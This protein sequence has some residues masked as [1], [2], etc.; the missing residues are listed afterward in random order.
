MKVLLIRP[1]PGNERFGLGPFFKVEPLGLEYAAAALRARG[2]DPVV[3]EERFEGRPVSWLRRHQAPVVGISCLHALEYDRV[4]E[5][6]RQVRRALPE[7]FIVIGG[8]AAAAWSAPLEGEA[9]DAIVTDDGEVILPLLVEAIAKRTPLREVPG[10][11]L[12]T[13]EGWVVTAS[14]ADRVDLDAVPAPARDLVDR[15]R[16]RYQCLLFRPVWLVETARGCPFRCSFCS[17]WPLYGRSFRERSIGAVVEDIV[18]AGPHLFI[19][20]DLFW[21]HPERSRELAAALKARGVRK[22][23]ILVQTRTDL[24]AAHPD[25]LE[26]W[27]PL[28]QDFDIFFGLEAPS[29]EGLARVRKDALVSESVQAAEVARALRYGVTGNFVV[30][31]DWGEE[32]FEA[33]RAFVTEHRFERAGYTILTPLPGTA[34][35]DDFAARGGGGGPWF[36]YDMHHALWEPRLGAARFFH[37]YAETWRRSILNLGG[38]KRWRDW[39]AQVRLRDLPA[40]Y[41]V[42]RRTQRMMRAGEY[43]A[44]HTSRSLAPA[45]G[46]LEGAEA[47]PHAAGNLEVGAR[48]AAAAREIAQSPAGPRGLR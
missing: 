12:R 16:S 38:R 22:R 39:A 20:D 19:V 25:L 43:L 6:A 35:Y 29:D 33:L 18:S 41:G 26:A 7:A 5:V 24:A 1:D 3:V 28:A 21:H 17:V 44:E 9:A 47:A 42:L 32:E 8:A 14:P 13:P 2:H 31:P 10:L 30:D 46:G 11:R 36:R 34:L 4:L 23:W 27:R 40:L 37:L 15:Y 45:A 48:L